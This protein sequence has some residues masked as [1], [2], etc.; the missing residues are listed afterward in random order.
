MG[1][2]LIRRLWTTGRV[3]AFHAV[4]LIFVAGAYES[5]WA[6]DA[7]NEDL[8]VSETDTDVVDPK[9]LGKSAVA[10]DSDPN[11]FVNSEAGIKLQRAGGWLVGSASHGAVALFRAAGETE[12][13]IEF[14]VSEDIA[15]ESRVSYVSAFQNSLLRVGFIEIE[16]RNRVNYSGRIGQEYEFRA[17]SNGIEFRLITWLFARETEVWIV[18]GFFPLSKRDAY[19]RDFQKFVRSLEFTD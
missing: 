3:F 11:V 17:L 16:A 2:A 13:Q 1:L 12:A 8:S 7:G 5:A 14:R 15:E 6:Q 9:A 19:F 10:S 4:I 18:S